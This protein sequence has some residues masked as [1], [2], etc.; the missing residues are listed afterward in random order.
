MILSQ[1]DAS[2]TQKID[3]ILIVSNVGSVNT[4]FGQFFKE[5]IQSAFRSNGAEAE[6]YQRMERNDFSTSDDELNKKVA[7]FD[8][9]FLLFI[10][11]SKVYKSRRQVYHVTFKSRLRHADDTV[12]SAKIELKT[13]ANDRIG[14]QTAG[15]LATDIVE[16][17][18]QD[19][20][21]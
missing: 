5:S 12:W 10:S 17:L 18:K 2:Y 16:K 14:R 20:L 7:V 19:G 15:I 8:P 4:K 21:L 11:P 3:R 9:N 6:A 13:G 1:K